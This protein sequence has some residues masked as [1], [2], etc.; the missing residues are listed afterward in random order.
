MSDTVKAMNLPDRPAELLDPTYVP[1]S[2]LAEAAAF[3]KRE[4]PIRLHAGN[5]KTVEVALLVASTYDGPV[6]VPVAAG[7]TRVD[8][9][10][11]IVTFVRPYGQDYY[12]LGETDRRGTQYRRI[13]QDLLDHA[14]T[15]EILWTTKIVGIEADAS[16]TSETT[17]KSYKDGRKSEWTWTISWS[18][19][20]SGGSA[21][22]FPTVR[23]GFKTFEAA[24]AVATEHVKRMAANKV[25]VRA[26][27]VPHEQLVSN[28]TVE[29][30]SA[31]V[32][33]A[34]TTRVTY[35]LTIGVYENHPYGI[36]GWVLDSPALG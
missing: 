6:A 33:S 25:A 16:M 27:I 11:E 7:M 1:I 19:P 29:L 22:Y 34:E 14:G 12:K 20:D 3:A 9:R 5:C 24:H 17:G 32:V 8:T 28:K 10:H 13:P 26:D 23:S 35:D 30:R 2:D 36:K 4:T 15:N 18:T 21:G 31:A